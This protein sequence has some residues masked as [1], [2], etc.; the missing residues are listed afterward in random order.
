MG[1]ASGPG[2][3]Q[4][5]ELSHVAAYVAGAHWHVVFSSLSLSVSPPQPPVA[6]S[7]QPSAPIVSSYVAAA[8]CLGSTLGCEQICPC[9]AFLSAVCLVSTL[10][11]EQICPCRAFPSAMQ[12]TSPL[13]PLG[14]AANSRR[15]RLFCSPSK[16]AAC[17]GILILILPITRRVTTAR[18][19]SS[20]CSSSRW[21]CP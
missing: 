14:P 8:V 15:F 5:A 2:R 21:R 20:S 13:Q 18:R 11:C 6:S 7:R 12:E 4:V 19:S 1:R 16:A 10:G 17:G 9:R 3:I